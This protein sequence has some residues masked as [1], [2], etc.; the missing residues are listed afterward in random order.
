MCWVGPRVFVGLKAQFEDTEWSKDVRI[1]THEVILIG[2]K[3]IFN[4][5]Y[6]R[7]WSEEKYVLSYVKPR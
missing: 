4:Q 3:K 6:P 7:S 1:S 5:V 2:K